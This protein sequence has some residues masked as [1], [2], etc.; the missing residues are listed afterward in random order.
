MESQTLHENF[1]FTK[2]RTPSMKNFYVFPFWS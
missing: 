1:L 2:T